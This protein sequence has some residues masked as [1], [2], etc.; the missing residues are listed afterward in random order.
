MLDNSLACFLVLESKKSGTRTY[1][2]ERLIRK[3]G[4]KLTILTGGRTLS[5]LFYKWLTL[6]ENQSAATCQLLKVQVY[7]LL[8]S[9]IHTLAIVPLYLAKKE[10]RIDS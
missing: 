8:Y 1:L 7:T 4:A 3:I 5:K 6:F 9:W 2:I 10:E